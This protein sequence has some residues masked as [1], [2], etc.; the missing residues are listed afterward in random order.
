MA[1]QQEDKQA[2]KD[3]LEQAAEGSHNIFAE[4][5]GYLAA[6]KKWWLAPIIAVLLLVAALVIAGGSAAAPFIYTLF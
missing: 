5:I 3:D 2:A 4:F 6:N 1:D